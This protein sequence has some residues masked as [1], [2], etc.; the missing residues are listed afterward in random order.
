MRIF[1]EAG[2]WSHAKDAKDAKGKK[3]PLE[4]ELELKPSPVLSFAAFAFFA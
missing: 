3:P 2:S 1:G 4:S